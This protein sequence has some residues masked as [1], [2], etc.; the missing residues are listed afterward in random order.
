M[1]PGLRAWYSMLCARRQY[2][3]VVFSVSD[4]GTVLYLVVVVRQ[5]SAGS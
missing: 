5:A 3:S 4:S 2:A 1:C